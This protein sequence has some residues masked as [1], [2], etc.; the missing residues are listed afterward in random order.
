MEDRKAVFAKVHRLTKPGGIFFSSAMRIVDVVVLFKYVAPVGRA[1]DLLPF[2]DIS[3]K[4][5][6]FNIE[7][8]WKQYR[9][10]TA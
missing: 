5:T 8:D 10:E 3:A 7:V 9:K 2:L 1:L 6:N 4:R